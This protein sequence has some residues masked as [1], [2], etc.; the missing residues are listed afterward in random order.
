MA[1]GAARHQVL[2]TR[3]A[4]HDLAAIHRH[5]ADSSGVAAAERLL[6]R[7]LEVSKGLSQSPDR[8][9]YPQELLHLGIK[10]YRQVLFKPWRLIYRVTGQQ[11]VI[12]LIVDGRR[13]LQ[14]LLARR[15]LED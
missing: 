7:L 2:L 9:S 13:D 1:R 10:E 6:D 5:L 11:V 8:G 15:L 4:E 14:S 12:Y 3:G